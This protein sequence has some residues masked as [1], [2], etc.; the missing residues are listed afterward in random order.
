MTPM[1]ATVRAG[2]WCLFAALLLARIG[3]VFNVLGW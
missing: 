1:D 3:Q 2:L